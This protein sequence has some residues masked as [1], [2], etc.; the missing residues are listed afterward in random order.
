MTLGAGYTRYEMLGNAL[1]ASVDE[2]KDKH[3]QTAM[4]TSV[5][6]IKEREG[7]RRKRRRRKEGR[8]RG[9]QRVVSRSYL[10]LS[11]LVLCPY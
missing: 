2:R 7:E 5:G 3:R 1:R 10:K 4:M 9:V 6:Q 11:E 8:D